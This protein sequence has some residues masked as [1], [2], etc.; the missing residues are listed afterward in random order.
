MPS[1]PEVVLFSLPEVE[2][3]LL[4]E[5]GLGVGALKLVLVDAVERK[6]F[7]CCNFHIQH[8]KTKLR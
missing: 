8:N 7:Q 1:P 6:V 4:S 3:P 2:L 5:V